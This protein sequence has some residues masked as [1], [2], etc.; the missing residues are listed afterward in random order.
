MFSALIYCHVNTSHFLPLRL[1]A[2]RARVFA[3][4]ALLAPCVVLGAPNDGAGVEDANAVPMVPLDP[5][6]KLKPPL[7]MDGAGMAA[8]AE[9]YEKENACKTTTQ[10]KKPN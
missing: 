8:G 7:G 4:S 10:T 9:N 5:G 2:K 3:E 6:L 1:A